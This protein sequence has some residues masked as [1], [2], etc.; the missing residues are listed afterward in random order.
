MF[1]GLRGKKSNTKS[2]IFTKDTIVLFS[3]GKAYWGTFRPLVDELI[4]QKIHFRYRTLDLYDPAL[5]IENPYMQSKRLSISSLSLTELAKIEAPI[6]ISTTPNIGCDGYPLPKPKKVQNLVHVF[7][8]V[9]DLSSYKRHS[10]DHYDSAILVGEFQT[11]S[12][13]DIE[14]LRGLKPKKLMTLGLPYLDDLYEHRPEEKNQTLRKQLFLSGL[15][16][17]IKVVFGLMELTSLNR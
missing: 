6:M 11:K 13:R 12:I 5:T 2:S 4:K 8:H 9:G 3:E 16:G 7:H 15:L 10:L 14:K 17:V 1:Y